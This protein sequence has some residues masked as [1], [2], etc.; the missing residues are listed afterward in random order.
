M[1]VECTRR[2]KVRW[3]DVD[4]AGI[5]F[6]PRFYEWYDYGCEA[7]FASLVAIF[8]GFADG[9]LCASADPPPPAT[10]PRSAPGTAES[11]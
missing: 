11:S 7:L 10:L 3:G 2:V 1:T 9:Q 8:P 6:Y 4:A 5:V